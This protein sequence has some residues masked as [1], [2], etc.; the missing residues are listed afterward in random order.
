MLLLVILNT[1]PDQLDPC[2]RVAPPPH[3]RMVPAYPRSHLCNRITQKFKGT[4]KYL[5]NIE[6]DVH[7]TDLSVKWIPG[8]VVLAQEL[9]VVG[10]RQLQVV[11]AALEHVDVLERGLVSPLELEFL[12]RDDAEDGPLVSHGLLLALCVVEDDLRSPDGVGLVLGEHV[13]VGVPLQVLVDQARVDPGGVLVERDIE[14]FSDLVNLE[15]EEYGW[16]TFV[17]CAEF[18]L[19]DLEDGVDGDGD[20]DDGLGA[21][22]GRWCDQPVV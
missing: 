6:Y 9:C 14:R 22:E 11:L 19:V 13:E 2:R 16:M 15:E 3:Y 21:V 17:N 5:Y 4:E 7:C 20:L 8:H 1:S 12:S 10:L 18:D